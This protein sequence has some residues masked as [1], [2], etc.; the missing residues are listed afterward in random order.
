MA[1]GTAIKDYTMNQSE[2][3]SD[4]SI[5]RPKEWREG[6]YQRPGAP[7]D[8]SVVKP[9]QTH[10]ESPDRVSTPVTK[11]DYEDQSPRTK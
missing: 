9:A 11:K 4:E 5:G 8:R 3:S 10:D 1:H 2:G 7:V 6:R